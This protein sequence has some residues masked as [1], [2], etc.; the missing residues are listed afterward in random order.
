MDSLLRAAAERIRD[1]FLT[2]VI[3]LLPDSRGRLEARASETITYRLGERSGRRT[4]ARAGG[5]IP[6]RPWS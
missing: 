5:L 4:P 6:R 2:Q 1:V 3:I